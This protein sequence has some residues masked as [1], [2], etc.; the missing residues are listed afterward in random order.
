M[1]FPVGLGCC[2]ICRLDKPIA[3]RV[4]GDAAVWGRRQS[5]WLLTWPAALLFELYGLAQPLRQL[6]DIC[7]D[8]PRGTACDTVEGLFS[9]PGA[10]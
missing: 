4:G 9:D 10:Q 2:G 5:R 8:P 3:P 7:R 1:L 6:G